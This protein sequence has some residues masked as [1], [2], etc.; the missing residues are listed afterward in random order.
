MSFTHLCNIP[1]WFLP[2]PHQIG[3]YNIPYT[4]WHFA[5][6]FLSPV[7]LCSSQSIQCF[8]KSGRLLWPMEFQFRVYFFLATIIHFVLHLRL[9]APSA[10][11]QMTPSWVVQ[12][13]RM[14]DR[15]SSRETSTGLRGGPMQTSRGSTRPNTR[16]CTCVGAISNI[17]TGWGMKRLRAALPRR[18]WG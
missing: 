1:D 6:Q 2:F 7:Q 9:S 18:T 16:S 13:I 5:K 15:V 12:L 8:M 4:S 3:H 14:R 11:L 10:S 17:N